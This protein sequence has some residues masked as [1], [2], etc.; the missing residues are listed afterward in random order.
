M[1]DNFQQPLWKQKFQ[2]NFT[3]M[4]HLADFLELG[5]SQRQQLLD[6]PKFPLN[7]PV[8]LAEKI[9]KG[10]LTDP[11]LKQFIP[12]VKEQETVPG[13]MR[14]PV[15][16]CQAVKGP[17]LLQKY[18]G[19]V[20]LL[21]TSACAMH[22]RYCFRQNFDYSTEDKTFEE[23]LA[24]IA[25]D[26]TIHEVILSG[27]D[28]L[29]LPN[30]V[31]GTLFRKIDAMTHIKRIRIHTRFIIGIPERIDDELLELMKK[32]TKQWWFVIH[33]NHPRELD[34]DVFIALKS[35]QKLGVIVLCQ[36][37]LLRGVNDSAEVLQQ[38]CELLVDNGVLPYYLHQLDPVQGS[39]HFEVPE[40][41]GKRLIAEISNK[42]PGY[43]VPKYVREIA[44]Y[45]SKTPIYE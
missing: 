10:D 28:P 23:E 33:A 31:L 35:L 43:A 18:E 37:V 34:L 11:I 9:A 1:N 30:R 40:D 4:K 5:P 20:L 6:A 39:A 19:R 27:G 7:L 16:D 25:Q 14:D 2:Q 32:S 42:L 38:L 22:C 8:R 12:T 36:A 17:K 29:S 45:P 21:C 3:Q 26:L 41:E 44:G 13:Y 15:G 24:L